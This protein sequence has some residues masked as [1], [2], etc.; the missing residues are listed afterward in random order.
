MVTYSPAEGLD[1][2]SPAACPQEALLLTGASDVA[3]PSNSMGWV[4]SSPQ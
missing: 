3:H 4:S 2:P 1:A